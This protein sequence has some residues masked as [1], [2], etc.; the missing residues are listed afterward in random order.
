[1]SK[2]RIIIDSFFYIFTQNFVILEKAEFDCDFE[3][4]SCGYKDMTT[5]RA[6]SNWIRVLHSTLPELVERDIKNPGVYSTT[7]SRII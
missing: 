3:E 6:K 7:C 1:M 5:F 4:D 2:Y